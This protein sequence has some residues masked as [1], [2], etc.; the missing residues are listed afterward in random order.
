M[1]DGKSPVYFSNKIQ[2][3][4][5]TKNKWISLSS[6]CYRLRKKSALT[7]F[8]V[9]IN[10]YWVNWNFSSD[11][12]PTHTSQKIICE[13]SKIDKQSLW[14]L[15]NIGMQDYLGLNLVGEIRSSKITNEVNLFF[16]RPFLL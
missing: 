8:V 10:R 5:S 4:V 3:L 15:K 6:E 13:I 12:K 1:L 9:F 2:T 16:N 11:I 14:K 7:R